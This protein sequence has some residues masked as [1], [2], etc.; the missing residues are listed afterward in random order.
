M[1]DTPTLAA[2]RRFLL[3]ALE[4]APPTHAA[5]ARA[6][7][8]LALAYHDAPNCEPADDDGDYGRTIEDY[9]KLYEHLGAR[10]PD[11]G[12][13]P[14]VDPSGTTDQENGLNDAI[15]DLADITRDLGETVWR[16]EHFGAADAHWHFK[17]NYQIHWGRH[18]RELSYYLYTKIS[19]DLSDSW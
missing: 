3:L 6:L 13:Y 15:D 17:F 5:L 2:A 18:L 12:Y 14:V 1:E 8:E 19:R 4:G 16:F 10:F 11:Y 7:D 9:Q